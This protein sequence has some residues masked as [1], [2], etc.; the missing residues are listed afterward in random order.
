MDFFISNA[1]AQQGEPGAGLMGLLFPIALIM[2]FYFLLIRPQQK[3]AK[4][5]KK[6]VE[7]LS[8]GDEVLTTGGLVGLITDVGDT[9]ATLEVAD[10]LEVKMQKSAVAQV[11]PKGS[12]RQSL[13]KTEP[14]K[15]SAK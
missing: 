10:N 2:I 1:M 4:E 8:K 7:N 3:R 6:L 11:L 13:E 15:A 14:T 9:F 12:Y 5:H